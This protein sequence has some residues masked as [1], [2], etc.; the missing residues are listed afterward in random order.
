MD[1]KAAVPYNPIITHDV[2]RY[3]KWKVFKSIFGESGRILKGQSSWSLIEA[4]RSFLNRRQVD[5]FSNLLEIAE[6]DKGMGLQSVFYIMTTDEKHPKNINDYSTVDLNIRETLKRLIA[7]GSEIGLHPG[8]LTF[9][10]ENRMR[11]QKEKLEEAVEK[12]VVRNRQHYLK[13]EYPTT[14]KILES[15]GIENDSSILVDISNVEEQAKR[16]TYFMSDEEGHKMN[17]SQTPL[18]F[19]DTH[20]MHLKDDAILNL[21]EQSVAPAKNN[22]GEI[23]ILWH[24]NNVSNNRELGLYKEALEVIK[25]V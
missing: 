25:G 18:V 21:L 11:D 20:H 23:M 7:T 6:M 1:T 22:G 2:D 19:M 12:E 17:I 16:S 5:P 15:I 10:D 13:F 9:N 24:N 4:W 14:F 8:I 3:Y